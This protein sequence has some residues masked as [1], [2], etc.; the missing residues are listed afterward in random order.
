MKFLGSLIT[1]LFIGFMQ[2]QTDP[3]AVV[4]RQLD[5]YNARDIEGFLATFSDSAKIYSFGN[6]TPLAIGKEAIRSI[7]SNMFSASPNLHSTLVNRIVFENKIFDHESITGRNG[8][9]EPLE[10]VMLYIVKNG[11]I[12]E[13]HSIRK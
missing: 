13:A 1:L 10:L 8:S 6:P 7:Y 12:V 9:S 3:E 4:Q 2:A 5:T 11:V